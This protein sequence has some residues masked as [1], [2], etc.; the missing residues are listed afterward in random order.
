M[1]SKNPNDMTMEEIKE[2]IA[3]YQRLYYHRRK[4]EK[5]YMQKKKDASERHKQKKQLKKF[6]EENAINLDEVNQ[7]QILQMMKEREPT[8][9]KGQRVKYAMSNF[10]L[11]IPCEK[12]Y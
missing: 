1:T 5:A 4:N 7:E 9:V 6:I 12:E 10:R 3:I 11:V 2:Q 8:R